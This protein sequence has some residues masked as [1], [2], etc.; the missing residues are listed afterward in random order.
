MLLPHLEYDA[1]IG[2]NIFHQTMAACMQEYPAARKREHCPQKSDEALSHEHLTHYSIFA[3]SSLGNLRVK[4]WGEYI[5]I[6]RKI[7]KTLEMYFSETV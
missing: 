3:N 7:E 1:C 4:L 6:R 2:S 5:K